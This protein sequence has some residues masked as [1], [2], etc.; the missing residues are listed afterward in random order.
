MTSDAG[1]NIV[2]PSTEANKKGDRRV[3]NQSDFSMHEA[4]IEAVDR[5]VV[6]HPNM[7][8]GIYL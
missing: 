4:A 1:R 5:K 8:I 2:S 3:S 6:K 7:P